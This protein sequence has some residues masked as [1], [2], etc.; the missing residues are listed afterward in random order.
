ML[1]LP[2]KTSIYFHP[3]VSNW[4]DYLSDGDVQAVIGSPFQSEI[5]TLIA[6]TNLQFISLKEI[7]YLWYLL[8]H[9]DEAA[10]YA[11]NASISDRNHLLCTILYGGEATDIDRSIDIHQKY[12]KQSYWDTLILY[13]E[14]HRIMRV[15][16]P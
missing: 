12:M 7:R 15:K 6:N 11:C 10:I 13:N 2:A 8:R 14:F 3:S 9:T 4:V 16:F 1:L 5:D